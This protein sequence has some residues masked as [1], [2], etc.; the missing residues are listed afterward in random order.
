MRRQFEQWWQSLDKETQIDN[1]KF[2]AWMGWLASREDIKVNLPKI[3]KLRYDGN[4]NPY[5]PS[6]CLYEDDFYAAQ[7]V[8]DAM[9]EVGV[10]Y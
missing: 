7:E 3:R 8:E 1:H 9:D 4:D 10:K 5:D 2:S 6:V